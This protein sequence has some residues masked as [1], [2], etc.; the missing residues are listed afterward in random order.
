MAFVSS[1]ARPI[2]LVEPWFPPEYAE[3]VR[4][5]VL[6]GFIGPGPA[7]QSFGRALAEFANAAGCVL[8]AS[9][10]VALSVAA[11]AIGLQAGDEILVPA[12]GVIATINAFASIGLHPRL[13]DIDRQTGCMSREDLHAAIS[14]RT[15]AVCFVNFSGH[16]GAGLAEIAADCASRGI[17]LIEDAAC[18][19]GHRHE[20]RAAGT[21][22]AIGVYSFSVPKVIT[23]GQGGALVSHDQELLDRA[24]ALIDHGDLEWRKTNLNRN[25]GTNLRF[26][27]IQAR[28][29]LCQVHDLK[30]RLARRRASFGVL[31]D[32]LGQYLY[33]VPGDEAPLHNIVFAEQPDDLV[34]ALRQGNIHAV[35]Q[36]RTLSQHP[37][38]AS[39]SGLYP[40]ADD[41]TNHA[42]YLPFGMSLTP[43][44]AEY[45][46]KAVHRSGMRLLPWLSD[47]P[48]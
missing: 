13:V 12:Y 30:I 36:Y 16:T 14:P 32:A 48:S 4:D 11:K 6:S 28:L 22:G 27:D 1:E 38:Y 29:G 23:T 2:P 19:L 47:E 7:T 46:A 40:N 43:E 21:F 20:G 26:T 31:R 25:V 15:R 18:A 3:A 8:T 33:Q 35:R 5:Q 17:P 45:V 10:T 37:A 9:G 24:A 41:W 44:D 34:A 42:V 39:L